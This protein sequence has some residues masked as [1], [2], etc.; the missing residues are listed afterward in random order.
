MPLAYATFFLDFILIL[1]LSTKRDSQC[2]K[3]YRPW[4]WT[5]NNSVIWSVIGCWRDFYLLN[6]GHFGLNERRKEKFQRW[7]KI[8]LCTF[9]VSFSIFRDLLVNF[10]Q[11]L[12]NWTQI[13]SFTKL[14][15]ILFSKIFSSSHSFFFVP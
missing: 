13:P 5:S 12:W 11:M 7:V 2:K 8:N 10:Y 1:F 14:L 3:Y 6:E 9:S 4:V 15:F